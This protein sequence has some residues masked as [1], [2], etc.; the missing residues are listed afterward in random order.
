MEVL[1]RGR[2]W[3]AGGVT[4]YALSTSFPAQKKRLTGVWLLAP[5]TGRTKRSRLPRPS[6]HVSKGHPS[7]AFLV[8]PLRVTWHVQRF[9]LQDLFE[10][11][12]SAASSCSLR[13]VCMAMLVG[14][15]VGVRFERCVNPALKAVA[16]L[17]CHFRRCLK[18]H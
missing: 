2:G 16:F 6:Q 7:G 10:D 8:T 13:R 18:T 12:V 14:F 9:L 4:T 15:I 1:S 3:V 11:V 17:N 5:R